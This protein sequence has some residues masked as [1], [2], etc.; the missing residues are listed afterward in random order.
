MVGRGRWERW[1]KDNKVKGKNEKMAIQETESGQEGESSR[2][3]WVIY[4]YINKDY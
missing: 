1:G 3:T 2:Q 4:D